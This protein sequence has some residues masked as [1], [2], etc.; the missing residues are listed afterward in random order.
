[1]SLIKIKFKKLYPNSKLPVKGSEEAACYD[2]YAHSV[3]VES[4]QL[5]TYK[6]GFSTEIPR[7]YKAI[8]IARS[9]LSK[10]PW[11]VANSIG[12][13]DSDYRGEWMIKMRSV[14]GN[15]YEPIPYSEGDRVGQMYLQ[16]ILEFEIEETDELQESKRGEGGFGSTGIK[17]IT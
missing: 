11:V 16:K 15:L 10:T 4:S 1:M 5:I 12:I 8:L 2:V 13:I 6:L 17:S 7:G 14:S 3:V 9:N